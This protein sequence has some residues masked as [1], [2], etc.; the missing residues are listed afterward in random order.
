MTALENVLVGMHSRLKGGIVR[1]VLRTPGLKRQ[2]RAAADRARELLRF[3]SLT[4]DDD[5]WARNLSYGDQRRLEVARALA[6]RPSLL[7]L[8]EVMAGL[9]PAE[10]DELVGGLRNLQRDEGITI[11]L[12]EHVMRAVMALADPVKPGNNAE[13]LG[14]I[15]VKN[16]DRNVLFQVFV[17]GVELGQE[18]LSSR[19]IAKSQVARVVVLL[20]A[21]KV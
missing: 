10:I 14:L 12:T 9:R 18:L 19:K 6:T 2:E 11:L 20:P 1:T 17:P 3:C 16:G 7:L 8:D 4:G 15:F 13:E 21:K 5:A